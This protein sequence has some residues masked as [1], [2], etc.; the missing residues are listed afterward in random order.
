MTQFVLQKKP[1]NY[2]LLLRRHNRRKH[3]RI[4]G[5]GGW[6]KSEDK[7]S[8]GLAR[9]GWLRKAMGFSALYLKRRT[10]ERYI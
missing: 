2:D 3:L 4:K 5:Q 10:T 9:A 8:I 7:Q 1:T 6:G